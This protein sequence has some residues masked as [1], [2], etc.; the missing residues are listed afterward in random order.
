MRRWQ[1]R[2]PLSLLPARRAVAFGSV[3]NKEALKEIMRPVEKTI[4]PIARPSFHVLYNEFAVHACR[5]NNAL[6]EFKIKCIRYAS[7]V[8]TVLRTVTTTRVLC[9]LLFVRTAFNF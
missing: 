6:Y 1:S 3:Q 8:R 2:A 7:H 5:K 4:K 9:H